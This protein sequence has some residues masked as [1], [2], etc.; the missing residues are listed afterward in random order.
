[1]DL[2]SP[3]Y[4][5]PSQMD[6]FLYW[7]DLFYSVGEETSRSGRVYFRNNLYGKRYFSHA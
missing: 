5:G 6:L 3:P 7:V 4:Q 1:M 2:F